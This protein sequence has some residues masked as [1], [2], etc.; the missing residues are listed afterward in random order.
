MENGVETMKMSRFGIL[1]LIS[2]TILISAGCGKILARRDVVDGAK[3]YK[4]RKFEDAERLFRSA[5]QRDPSQK[6]AELFLARTLHSEFAADR[7]LTAKADE[8][9]EVYKKVI[10][11]YIPQVAEKQK[12]ALASPNAEKVQKDY[13]ETLG[14]LSSSV[15]AVGNLLET[16]GK[17]EEWAKWQEEVG[18]N[19]D[20]PAEIRANALTSL[21]SRQY[22]CANEISDVEPVKKTVGEKFVFV[23]PANAEDFEKF[24][25]CVAKGMEYVDKALEIEKAGN[26]ETDST[27]SYKTSLLV[28]Q[29]R[30][31]EMEG[32]TADKD[33]LK[34]QSDDAKNRFNE[35]ATARRQREE[36]EERKR[37]EEEEKK[38]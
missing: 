13:K 9:I 23:K 21:A 32:R 3:A 11:D 18:N 33:S 4:D 25:G 12:A 26:V 28:Q 2:I 29:M 38:K 27:W 19:K 24:K 31:A 22:S 30:Q 37:K 7:S 14:I 1:V 16:T 8:A 5:M 10:P 6:V 15:G 34:K 35:L 17:K 36:E 20:L